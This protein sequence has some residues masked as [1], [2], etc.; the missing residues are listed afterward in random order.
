MPGLTVR[1]S[2]SKG[3][4]R[5]SRHYLCFHPIATKFSRRSRGQAEP[6]DV[7]ARVSPNFVESAIANLDSI[8]VEKVRN[9]GPDEIPAIRAVV[10]CR[11]T[12]TNGQRVRKKDRPGFLHEW[13]VRVG[14]A[15]LSTLCGQL[16]RGRPFRLIRR[17]CGRRSSNPGQSIHQLSIESPVSHSQATIL[18]IAWL[19][20]WRT[21]SRVRPRFSPTSRSVIG[22]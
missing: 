2:S 6:W 9:G 22:A 17:S 20:N 19:S 1:P 11:E 21:R 14:L 15:T 16:F 7:G 8:C 18:R 3:N 13:R 4:S 12:L 5:V 10:P